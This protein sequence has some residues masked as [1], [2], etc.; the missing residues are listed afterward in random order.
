MGKRQVI[1]IFVALSAVW[2]AAAGAL[3]TR[4]GELPGDVVFTGAVMVPL[5]IA[6]AAFTPN[7]PLF[8]RVIGRGWVASPK[9]AITFDDG[10]SA[11]Y[12]PQVLDALAAA[13]VHATFF[14]LGR[15]V[16]AHPEIAKRIVAEGHELASHGD[17]HS[18]LT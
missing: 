12:T 17:D 16:R 13:G 14:V 18:L 2:L 5:V 15:H 4:L 7:T 10:P 11:E 1:S 8:G 9:A 6:F 3:S